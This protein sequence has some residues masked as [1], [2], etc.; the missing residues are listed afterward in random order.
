MSHRDNIVNLL[1]KQKFDELTP[2]EE[3][4]LE[5]WI[6]ES[7]DNKAC[8]ARIKDPAW[9]SL[10]LAHFNEPDIEA[11]RNKVHEL[12]KKKKRVHIIKISSASFAAA[13]TITWAVLN[14]PLWVEH[15]TPGPDNT[16][17]MADTVKKAFPAASFGQALLQLNNGKLIDLDTA[18]DGV[19]GREGDV[20]IIKRNR[21]ITNI[22]M[23]LSKQQN[24]GSSILITGHGSHFQLILA[25]S[26]LVDLSADSWVRFDNIPKAK[27]RRIELSGEAYF[28]VTHDLNKPFFVNVNDAEIEVIGTEFNISSFKKGNVIKTSLVKGSIKLRANNN[29]KILSPGE[30]A[31]VIPG[32]PIKTEAGDINKITGWH[33][34]EFVFNNDSITTVMN[35][36]A[37]WYD[38]EVIYDGPIPAGLITASPISHTSE[39]NATLKTLELSQVARFK[40]D[41]RDPKL[42]RVSSW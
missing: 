8:Y 42:I 37:R 10:Q 30:T 5:Q 38:I 31:T 18:K 32:Q 27:E 22:I 23:G 29:T 36:L 12:I 40:R 33:K 15:S 34:G 3:A 21:Q 28:K 17:V 24:S 41:N 1:L 14:W 2:E 20:Q 13:A 4:I 39:L 6:N 16:V 9:E 25:D 26:S 11:G 35:E 19:I 7:D